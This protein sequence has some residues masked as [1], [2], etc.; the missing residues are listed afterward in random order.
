[1]GV[2]LTKTTKVKTITKPEEKQN[3]SNTNSTTCPVYHTIPIHCFAMPS[4]L[5]GL[6][7]LSTPATLDRRPQESLGKALALRWDVYIG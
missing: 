1:M 7:M 3:H 2:R 4:P 6:V 5:H